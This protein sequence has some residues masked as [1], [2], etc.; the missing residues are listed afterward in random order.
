MEPQDAAVREDPSH[1][2]VL[3]RRQLIHLLSCNGDRPL[4]SAKTVSSANAPSLAEQVCYRQ[5]DF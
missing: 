5:V 4:N 2:E 3:E 1:P